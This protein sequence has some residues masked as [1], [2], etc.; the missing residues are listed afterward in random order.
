MAKF[1][2]AIIGAIRK[3]WG[4]VGAI[5]IIAILAAI[6]F[7]ALLVFMPDATITAIEFIKGVF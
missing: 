1:L 5:A 3:I 7:F 6:A 2:E 4:F